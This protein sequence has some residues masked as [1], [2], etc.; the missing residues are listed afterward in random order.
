MVQDLKEWIRRCDEVMNICL[1][2]SKMGRSSQVGGYDWPGL[3]VEDVYLNEVLIYSR[4]CF[5]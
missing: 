5:Q 1:V 3:N 2:I 4:W